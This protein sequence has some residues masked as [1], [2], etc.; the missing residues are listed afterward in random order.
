M[1]E[2]FAAADTPQTPVVREHIAD[3]GGRVTANYA[4]TQSTSASYPAP[5]V[6]LPE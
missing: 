1:P 3:D 5:V 2:L 4:P 6:S